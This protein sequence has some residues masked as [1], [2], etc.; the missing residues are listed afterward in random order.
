MGKINEQTQWEHEVYQVARTDKIE[1]GRTGIANLQAQQLGN[2]TQWLKTMLE[3]VEYIRA[4]TFFKTSDDPDG[5]ITGLA[6]TP[7]GQV[8]QVA[9]GVDSITSF[10]LYVNDSGAAKPI[11]NPAGMAA[12]QQI[13]QNVT[14]VRSN[15]TE[16]D[17][18][19]TA[20]GET[21]IGGLADENGR[22]TLFMAENGAVYAGG[23]RMGNERVAAEAGLLWALADD[24]PEATPWLKFYDDGWVDPLWLENPLPP[25][26]VRNLTTVGPYGSTGNAF[27]P[28]NLAI[29][30]KTLKPVNDFNDQIAAWSGAFLFDGDYARGRAA[31]DWMLR[32][33]RFN[34]LTGSNSAVGIADY[35]RHWRAVNIGLTY[36]KLDKVTPLGWRPALLRWLNLLGDAVSERMELYGNNNHKTWA[37][38]A[39]LSLWNATGR[40]AFYDKA[41]AQFLTD[42]GHINDNGTINV[43]LLRGSKA[44]HYHHFTFGPLVMM[45]EI[46]QLH[47]ED[48]YALDG[49]RIHLLAETVIHGITDPA[50]FRTLSGAGTQDISEIGHGWGGMPFYVRRFPDVVA[51]RMPETADHYVDTW[52]GGDCNKLSTLWVK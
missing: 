20:R 11:A 52:M 23:V 40:Q 26:A 6:A 9:Q 46:A 49:G 5:T 19:K 35:D 21:I 43:E 18:Q 16:G 13:S 33:A 47:G 41:A 30:E 4:R 7:S 36:W 1:G 31:A 3:S 48:W 22:S 27:D 24:T 14:D 17:A 39:L 12:I 15:V 44:L 50:W 34:A 51:G 38:C 42:L 25:V 28:V 8:F 10:T 29:R 2:R 32:W 45:C 37:A